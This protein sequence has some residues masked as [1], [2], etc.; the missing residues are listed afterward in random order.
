MVVSPATMSRAMAS[1]PADDPAQAVTA[2]G[3]GG[4]RAGR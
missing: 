1:L 2:L 4:G 3:V